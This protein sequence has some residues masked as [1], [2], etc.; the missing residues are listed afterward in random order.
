MTTSG[1]GILYQP[2]SWGK[3][4]KGGREKEEEKRRKR[5]GGREKGKRK[6]GEGNVKEK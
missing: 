6:G 5:K 1:G 4:C 3:I 2:M